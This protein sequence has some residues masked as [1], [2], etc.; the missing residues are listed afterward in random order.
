MRYVTVSLIKYCQQCGPELRI[1]IKLKPNSVIQSSE[2]TWSSY[3]EALSF[4]NRVY[5]DCRHFYWR[6]L[7]VWNKNFGA[8]ILRFCLFD[9]DFFYGIVCISLASRRRSCCAERA[10]FHYIIHKCCPNKKSS[11]IWTLLKTMPT[12]FLIVKLFRLLC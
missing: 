4:R 7:A 5:G 6:W 8:T 2:L 11:E 9:G 12:A 1:T 3:L 10:R